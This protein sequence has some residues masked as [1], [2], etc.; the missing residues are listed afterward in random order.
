MCTFLPDFFGKEAGD[1]F[2]RL[3]DVTN[4]SNAIEIAE[5]LAAGEVIDGE[6]IIGE[7]R[8]LLRRII[9]LAKRHISST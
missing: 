4:P 6:Q 8:K 3:V 7:R 5:K 2:N 9:E 1:T